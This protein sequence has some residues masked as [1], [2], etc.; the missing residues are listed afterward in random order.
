MCTTFMLI[1]AKHSTFYLPETMLISCYLFYNS[2]FVYFIYKV[3]R[4]WARININM[5]EIRWS[6]NSFF[7]NLQNYESITVELYILVIN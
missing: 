2:S 5:M 1:G 7:S 3:E 4:S 6:T